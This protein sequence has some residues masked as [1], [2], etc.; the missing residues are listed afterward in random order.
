VSE[1][2]AHDRLSVEKQ[3]TIARIESL[4]RDV[5]DIDAGIAVAKSDDE[6]DP[7]GSTLAIERARLSTLLNHSRANLEE[8]EGAQDRVA[9]GTYGTCERC[10]APIPRERLAARPVART[11]VQCRSDIG[12]FLPPMSSH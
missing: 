4:S 9:D 3:R 10:G 1:E 8:I 12:S 7:E 2:S 11:C 5:D 6:H